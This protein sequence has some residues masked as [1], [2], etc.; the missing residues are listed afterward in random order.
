M[1]D[2]DGKNRYPTDEN[3]LT[4]GYGDYVRHFLRAM[5]Y[6][7]ELAPSDEEHILF[8]SSV[9]QEV[10]Y[11]NRTSANPFAI[12]DNKELG[13]IKIR[14]TTY[15]NKGIEI[16]RLLEKPSKILINGEALPTSDNKTVNSYT[17]QPMKNGGILSV[18]RINGNEVTIM[19]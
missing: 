13:N 8:S 1:V 15:D 2:Y 6:I 11:K 9:V 3:W 7:P 17:W 4:D 5:G 16:V 12:V 14:Y 10:E 19:D 18:N